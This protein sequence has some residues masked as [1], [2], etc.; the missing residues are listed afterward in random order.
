MNTPQ[1]IPAAGP[2]GLAA[3]RERHHVYMTDDSR[4]NIAGLRQ[5]N[6]GYFVRAVA[7]VLEAA[8]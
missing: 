3:L 4:M 1:T 2:A 6:L 8:R 5:E 7:Q